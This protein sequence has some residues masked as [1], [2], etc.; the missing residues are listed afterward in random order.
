MCQIDQL[1]NN[2]TKNLFRIYI[3]IQ[4]AQS[5]GPLCRLIG[6]VPPIHPW[7]SIQILPFITLDRHG[8]PCLVTA[9]LPVDPAA[10]AVRAYQ[11][12][13]SAMAWPK[14]NLCSMDQ[15]LQWMALCHPDQVPTSPVGSPTYGI[16]PGSV[17]SGTL[18]IQPCSQIHYSAGLDWRSAENVTRP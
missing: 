17:R 14:L 12:I 9:S 3:A 10:T 7:W 13:L 1:K 2:V 11:W 8:P 15:L 5:W 18:P 4:I 16:R 6:L